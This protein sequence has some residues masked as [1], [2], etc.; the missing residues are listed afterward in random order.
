MTVLKWGKYK[1]EDIE[2]VPLGYLEW[3]LGELEEQVAEKMELI[4]DIQEELN[5]R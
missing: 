3:L 4:E 2:D 5:H 1:D